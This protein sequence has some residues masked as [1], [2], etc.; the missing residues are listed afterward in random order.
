MQVGDLVKMRATDV[1]YLVTK[2][3][4]GTIF[5][6][7]LDSNWGGWMTAKFFEVISASR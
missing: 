4:G 5:V 7:Q 6:K 2:V 3:C 1:M